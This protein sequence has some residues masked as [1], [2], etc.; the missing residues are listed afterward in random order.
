M[1]HPYREL[2]LAIGMTVVTV[3]THVRTSKSCRFLRQVGSLSTVLV[4]VMIISGPAVQ[5]KQAS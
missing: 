2:Q 4:M 1:R 5:H 3:V